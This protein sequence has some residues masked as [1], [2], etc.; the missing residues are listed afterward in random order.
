VRDLKINLNKQIKLLTKNLFIMR[1]FKLLALAF[2]FGTMSV[3]ASNELI[4]E[5]VP[6]KVIRNQ[7]VKLLATPNFAVEAETQIAISFTFNSEG[8]IVVLSVNSRDKHILN[9]VRKNING[10]VIDMPGEK[11]KLYTMPLKIEAI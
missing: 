5:D 1:K 3:F 4:P 11:D 6:A 7:I 10:K 8:E 9:Y 2:V